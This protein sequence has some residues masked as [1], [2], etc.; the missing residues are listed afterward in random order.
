MIE[1]VA[2][3]GGGFSGTL[4]A[5][6]LIRFDG[7]RATL[8]ER[9]P[10]VGRGVAYGLAHSSHLLNV[11]ASNMSPFPDEPDHLLR[12][13][14]DNDHPEAG[15]DFITRV[16]YGAYLHALLDFAQRNHPDRLEI[17]QG[18]AIDI[19]ERASIKVVLTDGR[20]IGSD[21]AVLA[22]GNLP[23]HA[24]PGLDP[25]DLS[26]DAY[27]GDPWRPD[28]LAGLLDRDTLLII[29]TGLTMVDV[30]LKLCAT[31]FRGKIIALSRR[32]LLPHRHGPASQPWSKLNERPREQLSALVNRVRTRG[33]QIGWRNA[34]DELRP[35]TQGIWSNASQHERSR[36]LRH[37]R[38]WWDIHR[39]RL[40]PSVAER[41][42]KLQST[43]QLRVIA[44]KLRA[45][46]ERGGGIDVSIRP[47]GKDLEQHLVVQR[48]INCTGPQGDLDRT[49]EPL[50]RALLTRGAIRPD[51]EHLGIDVDPGTRTVN[52]E[53]FSNDRLF[54]LGPMTRGAYWEIVA[55]PDIRRQTWDLARRLSNAHWVGGEG[56]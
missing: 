19:V 26:D 39:H 52:E 14:A 50:I 33:D 4:Q 47:R 3:I 24:P 7:P 54:A 21:A 9:A 53:G 16:T 37:L 27:K 35:F 11:R 13:L 12:W 23:P 51:A 20:E 48:I 8:I 6:N 15:S 46:S 25:D 38:P 5:L 55:V 31:E 43:G 2:I 44:G 45:V 32:G 1:H 42:A 30:V 36:F 34:V 17:V 29:G 40:A 49:E 41:I 28:T 56:L 18:E 10:I 22:V